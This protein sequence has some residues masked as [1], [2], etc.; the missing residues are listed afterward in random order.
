MAVSHVME[1]IFSITL[2]NVVVIMGR[3]IWDKAI[4]APMRNALTVYYAEIKIVKKIF[5]LSLRIGVV[6]IIAA[7]VRKHNQYIFFIYI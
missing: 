6:V 7:L 1:R 4:A 2:E 5:L 3:A